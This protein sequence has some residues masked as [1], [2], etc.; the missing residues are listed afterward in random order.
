MV[1]KE[2]K[3]IKKPLNILF[4]INNVCLFIIIMFTIYQVVYIGYLSPDAPWGFAL[5]MEDILSNFGWQVAWIVITCLVAISRIF[6]RK[7]SRQV[8]K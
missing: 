7:E 6:K 5:T 8:K 4:K 2:K 3:M 1:F